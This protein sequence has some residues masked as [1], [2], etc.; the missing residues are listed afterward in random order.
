MDDSE[1]TPLPVSRFEFEQTDHA[2]TSL[3]P[4]VGSIR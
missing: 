1:A 2:G 3:R 4:I